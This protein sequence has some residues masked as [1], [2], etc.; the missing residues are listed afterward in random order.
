MPNGDGVPAYKEED[1]M[2]GQ[3]YDG[4]SRLAPEWVSG[5]S[6]DKFEQRLVETVVTT[7]LA[8]MK[9]TFVIPAEYTQEQARLYHA[10][11]LMHFSHFAWRFPSWLLEIAARCPYQEVRRE[12]IDDCSD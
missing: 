3:P 5:D 10:T 2:P 6:P 11:S 4:R 12:I 8:S 9:G 7:A 1:R